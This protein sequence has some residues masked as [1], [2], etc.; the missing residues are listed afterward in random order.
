MEGAEEEA[1]RRMRGCRCLWVLRKDGQI[2]NEEIQNLIVGAQK[3]TGD[4]MSANLA[5]WL[6]ESAWLG[7]QALKDLP[8]K[9]KAEIDRLALAIFTKH[10]PNDPVVRKGSCHSC[11]SKVNDWDAHCGE[12]GA[13]FQ[14]CVLSGKAILDPA[15]AQRCRACKHVYL[16][17]EAKGARNCGLCH[18]PLPL[19]SYGGLN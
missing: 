18:S 6:P 2:D 11:G 15:N 14:A 10:P 7:L 3:D 5:E 16:E 12:C 1:V 17:D 9:K 19:A 4:Q 13:T 8:P